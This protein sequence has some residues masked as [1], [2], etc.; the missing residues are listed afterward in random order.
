MSKRLDLLNSVVGKPCEGCSNK[1][2]YQRTQKGTVE[3]RT[4]EGYHLICRVCKKCNRKALIT[5]DNRFIYVD[6]YMEHNPDMGGCEVDGKE[7]TRE[8]VDKRFFR[9][10]ESEKLSIYE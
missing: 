8:F 2:I 3:E 10:V 1:T 7:I 6:V 4:F 9:A 5:P